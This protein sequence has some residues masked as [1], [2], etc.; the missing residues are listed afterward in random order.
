L[1]Y[2]RVLGASEH[3]QL[4]LAF[5]ARW[6]DWY[7]GCANSDAERNAVTLH[8]I[9]MEQPGA[10]DRLRRL[11]ADHG[12]SRLLELREWGDGYQLDLSAASFR[13]NGAEGFWTP[14]D[15]TWMVYASHESSITVGGD[16]LIAGMRRALRQFDDYIYRGWDLAAYPMPHW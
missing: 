14:A 12:V 7:G 16:W 5:A 15:M 6:G 4:H 11:L 10:Y 8:D 13:Y 3:K 9:V 1:P 2:R